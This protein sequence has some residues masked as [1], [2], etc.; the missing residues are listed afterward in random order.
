MPTSSIETD[1]SPY[2]YI[3]LEYDKSKEK[4]LA[5]FKKW[6]NNTILRSS[7][8]LKLISSILSARKSDGGCQI[9][10]FK[11]EKDYHALLG[12]FAL[13]DLVELRTLEEKWLRFCQ[14]NFDFIKKVFNAISNNISY[15]I[16]FPGSLETKC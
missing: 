7:D 3:Y 13:H 2:D 1:I 5:I 12:F 11:L 6:S 10:V 9:N 4:N 16:L 8:R 14:V 15:F